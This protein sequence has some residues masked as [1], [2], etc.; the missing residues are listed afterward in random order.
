MLET[1][2]LVFAMTAFF[3]SFLFRRMDDFQLNKVA[4]SLTAIAWSCLLFGL[5]LTKG[6]IR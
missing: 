2:V 6:L 5:Y 4:S 1:W 3:I